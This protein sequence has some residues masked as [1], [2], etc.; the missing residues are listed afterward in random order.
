[1]C[2]LTRWRPI[3]YWGSAALCCSFCGPSTRSQRPRRSNGAGFLFMSSSLDRTHR[4]CGVFATLGNAPLLPLHDFGFQPADGARAERYW[5]GKRA[6]DDVLINSAAFFAGGPRGMGN[7]AGCARRERVP[8]LALWSL[9]PLTRIARRQSWRQL[10]VVVFARSAAP[11]MRWDR[12]NG[13]RIEGARR[14]CRRQASA[15]SDIAVSADHG[16]APA[17]GCLG[18]RPRRRGCGCLS[19]PSASRATRARID[20][21]VIR[22]A[23]PSWY[24]TNSPSRISL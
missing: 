15:R 13:N 4:R 22:R 19:P 20:S 14:W 11:A 17:L 9:R 1:V 10:R 21:M 18:G 16:C 2:R 8:R 6:V 5:R 12:A 7:M 23:R 24:V 3:P